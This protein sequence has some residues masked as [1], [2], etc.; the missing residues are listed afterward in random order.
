MYMDIFEISGRF[1]FLFFFN[2]YSNSCQIV[3]QYYIFIPKT[4][5][6]L[7]KSIPAK[8][9]FYYIPFGNPKSIDRLL[10]CHF[11]EQNQNGDQ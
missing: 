11:S 5:A 1:V 8:Y 6:D 7:K 3:H 4:F 10:S 9:I 2:I